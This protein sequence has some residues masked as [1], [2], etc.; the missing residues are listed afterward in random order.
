MR[1]I[2]ITGYAGSG[3]DSVFDAIGPRRPFVVRA[4]F[5]DALKA[6]VAAAYGVDVSLFHDPA[7]KEV[8]TPALAAARCADTRFARFLGPI[9]STLGE[10]R[11]RF[12][13]QQWGDWRREQDPD[14]WVKRLIPVVEASRAAGAQALVIT[15]VR[16]V[17]EYLW[18]QDAGG[19]LWR[20]AR[21]GVVPRCGHASEWQL[22]G[23]RA[24]L[25]IRNDGTLEELEARVLAA[26]DDLVGRAAA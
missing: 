13:M 20:V 16:F 15:D 14:Y 17:N 1:L 18:L 8:S 12:V 6:E 24:D 26:Y 4:A 10:L 11:P 25:T 23:M 5:A 3:K 21:A 22:E 19:V 2:G 7:A 9:M